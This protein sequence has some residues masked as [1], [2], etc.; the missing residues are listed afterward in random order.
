MFAEI[1]K[2][3]V[4]KLGISMLNELGTI[5]ESRGYIFMMI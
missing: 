4:G 2:T 3:A 1:L 5:V